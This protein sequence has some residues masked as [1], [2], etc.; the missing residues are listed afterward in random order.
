MIY[1]ITGERNFF[2]FQDIVYFFG[3]ALKNKRRLP[4]ESKFKDED[5]KYINASEYICDSWYE[6]FKEKLI[7]CKRTDYCQKLM[8]KCDEWMITTN[9]A[10]TT[11]Q[12]GM[13]K[14]GIPSW[15][16][17]Y[18]DKYKPSFLIEHSDDFEIYTAHLD[19]EFETLFN[20][21]LYFYKSIEYDFNLQ[22]FIALLKRYFVFDD[23]YLSKELEVISDTFVGKNNYSRYLKTFEKEGD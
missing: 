15:E 2:L 5:Y 16:L 10:I 17:D 8:N 3:L 22:S 6:V 7:Q 9:I 20:E 13:R 23:D 1:R 21:A 4:I 19:G 14:E 12:K 11:A 18:I